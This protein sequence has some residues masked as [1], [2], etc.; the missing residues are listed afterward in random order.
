[1]LDVFIALVALLLI[2]GS[3]QLYVMFRRAQLKRRMRSA[4]HAI[5]DTIPTGIPGICRHR[6]VSVQREAATV[7]H[8]TTQVPAP[9][10]TVRSSEETRIT[11]LV[12]YLSA[13]PIGRPPSGQ[14]PRQSVLSVASRITA[15]QSLSVRSSARSSVS[16]VT[17]ARRRSFDLATLTRQF[18]PPPP[19]TEAEPISPLE[20]LTRSTMA[21]VV[22][23]RSQERSDLSMNSGSS[24]SSHSSPQVGTPMC[25]DWDG[26][27]VF[28]PTFKAL[29]VAEAQLR[30]VPDAPEFDL[31]IN[32]SRFSAWTTTSLAPSR[33][34][35]GLLS[36]GIERLSGFFSILSR[37]TSSASLTSVARHQDT[38]VPPMPPVSVASPEPARISR[39]VAKQ[40]TLGRSMSTKVLA[41]MFRREKDL[42][43]TPNTP[44]M[45]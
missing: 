2:I 14:L 9:P 26:T 23:L 7:I 8:T 45:V 34:T 30:M 21:S 4:P 12:D 29:P 19:P 22:S 20:Q 1:M 43:A 15:S 33:K 10:V 32:Q 3:H 6:P 17:P 44:N 25:G 39:N 40:G 13:L 28:G 16:S 18:P 11:R 41:D 36:E 35:R 37:K 42:D 38:A 31:E 5:P 27:T 24:G